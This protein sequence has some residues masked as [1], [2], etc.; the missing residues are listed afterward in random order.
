MHRLS[1][2][3]EGTGGRHVHPAVTTDRFDRGALDSALDLPKQG[4]TEP[5]VQLQA[6]QRKLSVRHFQLSGSARRQPGGAPEERSP[7]LGSRCGSQNQ[8]R[9]FTGPSCRRPTR[10]RRRGEDRMR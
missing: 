10:R 4:N 5:I 1:S 7:N 3:R 2:G 9:C 8:L 6:R